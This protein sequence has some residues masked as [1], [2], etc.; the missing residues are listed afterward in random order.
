MSCP[1]CDG[2]GHPFLFF[3]V[4]FLLATHQWSCS[5]NVRAVKTNLDSLTN[6]YNNA[7]SVL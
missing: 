5:A 7:R 1:H 6:L 3:A 4:L 2:H